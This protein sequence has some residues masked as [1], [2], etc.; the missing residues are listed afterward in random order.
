MP[1]IF[2]RRSLRRSSRG[3]AAFRELD[4][5]SWRGVWGVPPPPVNLRKVSEGKGLG[6]Y[7]GRQKYGLPERC[8]WGRWVLEGAFVKRL[9]L[10]IY[11]EWICGT[12]EALP[13]SKTASTRYLCLR[14][15]RFAFGFVSLAVLI[16]RFA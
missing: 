12:A 7:F 5:V 11:R 4:G 10:R 13:L 1:I 15:F 8:G 16:P 3:L 9:R 14:L 6:L 2:L